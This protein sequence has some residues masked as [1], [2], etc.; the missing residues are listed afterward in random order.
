[1]S[2]ILCHFSKTEKLNADPLTNKLSY[3][4]KVYIGEYSEEV[5]VYL[6]TDGCEFGDEVVEGLGSEMSVGILVGAVAALVLLL[7]SLLGFIAWKRHCESAY[8]YL[9]DPPRIVQ[10]VGIPDWEGEPG[11]DG[12]YGPVSV[13]DFPAHVGRLHADSDIGFSREYSEILRY[14]VDGVNASSEHSSHPD[15]KHKNRCTV[16]TQRL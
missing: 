10:P 8:C 14:S 3:I 13:D 9:E 7:V 1:M 16:Y 2:F 15:N 5:E 6:S 12:E 4:S 11:P